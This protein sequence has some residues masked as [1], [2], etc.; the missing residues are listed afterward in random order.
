MSVQRVAVVTGTRADYGL[1]YWL[2]RELDGAPDFE[3]RVIATGMHLMPRHG[4]TVDEI[5]RDGFCV[6]AKVDLA[7]T[8]DTPLAVAQA[9]GRAVVAMA[10]ALHEL[11]PDWVVLLG[12]RYEAVAAALAAYTLAI[13]I[14]HL[15]GGEVTLGAL[16]DGY[17]HAI[18][19]WAALHFTAAEPYRRRVIQ[20][21]EHPDRVFNV[22]APGLEHL[23][24]T[25]LLSRSRLEAD[26]GLELGDQALLVT[27]HPATADE[28]EPVQQTLELLAALDELPECRVVITAPNS[29]AGHSGV[30]EA[31][32][33]YARQRPDRCRFVTS[34]GHVRYWSLMRQV[35]AVVGN[36]SSG[37]IEAPSAGCATVNIGS[38][39]QGRLRAASVVDCPPQRQAIVR[40][41]RQVLHPAFQVGLAGVANPYGDGMVSQAILEVLRRV[42]PSKLG[43]KG[44]WDLPGVAA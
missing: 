28:G 37:I 9:A 11:R 38:R 17:R 30:F 7:Q 25:P 34:L 23:R 33:T 6:A 10:G 24:R 15:H 13:P 3:L 18:T 27:F 36:S 14:A 12:D 44:F 8:D 2:M 29:D 32:Q 21:G 16:D 1:L 40:A 39:Q 31:M 35:R 42:D 19:K 4:H 20:M 22:G 41:L 26:L 5:E 43:P